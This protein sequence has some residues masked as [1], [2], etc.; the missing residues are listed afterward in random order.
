MAL[1]PDDDAAF[2]S[3][4]A[5]NPTVLF[6]HHYNAQ[7]GNILSLIPDFISNINVNPVHNSLKRSIPSI[8]PPTVPSSPRKRPA[9]SANC[10]TPHRAALSGIIAVA[11]IVD[12]ITAGVDALIPPLP[13]CPRQHHHS[14]KKQNGRG[15]ELVELQ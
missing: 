8:N 11:T 15:I 2:L 9:V 5:L 7:G 13:Y 4:D 14:Q 12:P 6:G 10:S 1:R 3:I